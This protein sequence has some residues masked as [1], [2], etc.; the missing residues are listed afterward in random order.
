MKTVAI[1]LILVGLP[2]LVKAQAPCLQEYKGE[3]TLYSSKGKGLSKV[4]IVIDGNQGPF[5]DANGVFRYR[6][7]K[8]PGMTVQIKIGNNNWDIVNH[9]EVYTYTLRRLADPADFQF[10]V[11]VAQVQEIEKARR[12][13]YA[14]LAGVA[15]DKGL[16]LLKDEIDKLKVLERQQLDQQRLIAN[17]VKPTGQQEQK[18]VGELEKRIE[19]QQKDYQRIVDS[20]GRKSANLNQ[21]NQEVNQLRDSLA[22]MQNRYE[23]A[24]SERDKRLGEAKA[25]AAVFAQQTEIDSSYQQ[26]FLKYKEGQFSGALSALSD[27]P[28]PMGQQGFQPKK[29]TANQPDEAQ[30]E[31]AL[32][33][34]KCLFKATIYRSQFDRTQAV[35]WYEEAIRTDTTQVENIITYANFLQQQNL[36]KEPERWYLKAL[37]LDPLAPRKADIYIELGYYY[38]ANNR[39]DNAEIALLEAK[40]IKQKLAKTNV[41]Q[42]EPGLAR[43][44]DGLGN[45]YVKKR[46]YDEAEKAYVQARNIREKLV[47]KYADDYEADLAFSLNN[48]GT[49]YYINKRLGEAGKTYTRAKTIQDRL[50]RRNADQYEPDLASTLGNLGTL[51]YEL[52]RLSDA[53][54]AYKQ[55][56][57]IQEKLVQKNPDLYE[58]GQARVLN[59]LGDLY[60]ITK[61][62][63]DAEIAYKQALAIR[64]KLAQKNPDQFESDLAQTLADLGL[65]YLDSKRY[66]EAETAYVRAKT[67]EEKLAGKFP[68]LFNPQ[69]AGTLADMGFFYAEMKRYKEAEVAYQQAKTLQEKLAQKQPKEFESDL[70]YTLTDMGNFYF[71]T[72][73]QR[74][75]KGIYIRAKELLEKMALTDDYR[76]GALRIQLLHRIGLVSDSEERESYFREADSL[77]GQAVELISKQFGD[78]DST[79]MARELSNWS[80]HLLFSKKFAKAEAIAEK[81]LSFD[82]DEEWV[83]ANLA[84]AYLMQGKLEQAKELYTYLKDKRHRSS[85]YKKTFLADLDELETAGL[86]HPD[87]P[88]I[89]KLLN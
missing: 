81:A 14:E 68:E 8:C 19:Q 61:R 51:N 50:V 65:F 27:E 72:D 60:S 75:A 11:L 48:L 10:K 56:K 17:Q 9:T 3:V 31:R 53:E 6:L 4:P 77:Q 35:H 38:T 79:L 43:V 54:T 64:E 41:E 74:E 29:S 66:Q 5:T 84:V 13:Y 32:Y 21:K 24:L 25:I 59:D 71:A 63:D 36:P 2:L 52:E 57:T 28:Q 22:K 86:T 70:A 12:T 37:A 87:M 16:S 73:R 58:P 33:I 45:L 55:A 34:S 76:L 78:S 23:L 20:L 30:R 44:L 49:F 85:K 39:Y 80:Y 46:Q 1:A 15:L 67:I 83:K 47:E 89:R 69:L 62:Y 88:T 82:E 42:Y 7:S 26:A 40:T 18:K